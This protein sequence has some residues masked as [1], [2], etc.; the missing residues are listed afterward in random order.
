[1]L[2]W[3][4]YIGYVLVGLF[5][6]RFLLPLVGKMKFQKPFVKSQTRQ[7]K[8]KK[9]SYIIFYLC[10]V[11]SLVTGLIIMFGPSLFK[12]PMGK[13]HVLSIYYLIAFIVVHIAGIL[14]AEF[15]PQKDL[16]SRIV[17]SSKKK[18]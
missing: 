2:K 14:Y 10:V 17:S 16:I 11:V 9:W 12:K 6:I 4:F 3:H 18:E 1:M 15:T 7:M 13:I 8:F 5:S